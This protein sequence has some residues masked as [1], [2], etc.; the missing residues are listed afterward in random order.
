MR[1][2][3]RGMNP[4][5]FLLLC[6]FVCAMAAR[7]A[8]WKVLFDGKSL[9][10]WDKF[11]A[12]GYGL[13]NDPKNVFS[14][15]EVDGKGAIHVSG[16]IYGAVTT[17]D[18]FENFHLKLKFKWG[19]K[20]WPARAN[21][22]RDSG[23]LYCCVGPHGAGSGAWMR[24]VECNIME[25]A[26]GQW[27]SVAGAIV[28]VEG[29]LITPEMEPWVPYKKESAGERNIVYLR[30]T[31]LMTVDASK[32]ITPPFDAEKYD[33]AWNDVEVYFWGGNCVHILNGR[34]NM[35]LVNPRYEDSKTKKV[36]SLR[37]GKIQLQ[38][39]AAEVFYRDIQIREIDALP[40]EFL[41]LIPSWTKR[42]EDFEKLFAGGNGGKWKQA[43]PGKFELKDGVARASGGMGLWWFPG[44]QYTNFVM[45]GEFRQSGYGADS[46]IFVRF[47]DPKNDPWNAVKEGHEIEIGDPNPADPTWR[48]GSIYPFKASK[49]LNICP[50]AEWNDYE[51]ICEDQNYSVWINGE[52]VTT[53]TDPKGRSKAGYIGLQNYNDGMVVEH[54]NIRIKDLP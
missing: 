4:R 7:G 18:E 20:K 23:I 28:D 45:R 6:I 3:D 37:R 51:I 33:G 38:S 53:W 25:R 44:R 46:G 19:Q 40:D 24:S 2:Y 22:G 27:W 21:V 35:I 36:D 42:E 10:G 47:P 14:V 26:T 52:L 13:N 16:E 1:A 41:A 12:D 17:K 30:G 9:E 32:G 11:L 43:G 54:R 31:P 34:V 39:E 8:E 15:S 5:L 49:L 48:T 50:P 29:K